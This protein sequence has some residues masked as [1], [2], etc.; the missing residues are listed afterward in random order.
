MISKCLHAVLATAAVSNY[1]WEV[2]VPDVDGPFGE[3]QA[4]AQVC[5]ARAQACWARAQPCWARAQAC[6]ER[7]A[8]VRGRPCPRRMPA[9]IAGDASRRRLWCEPSSIGT[10]SEI[11]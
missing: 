8:V 6:W 9:T 11:G 5:W 1:R 2:H 3:A 10:R 4:R 7:V